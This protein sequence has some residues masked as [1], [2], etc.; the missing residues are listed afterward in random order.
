MHTLGVVLLFLGLTS[1]GG[2][3]VFEHES[4]SGST[5]V[6]FRRVGVGVAALGAVMLALGLIL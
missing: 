3:L 1:L 4:G 5:F 6:A 2:G